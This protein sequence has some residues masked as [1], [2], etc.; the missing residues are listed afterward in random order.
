MIYG[1][2]SVTYYLA[3]IIIAVRATQTYRAK[4]KPEREVIAE[5]KR[6]KILKQIETKEETALRKA[7]EYATAEKDDEVAVIRPI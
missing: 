1:F 4:V 5:E 7:M 6:D 2:V 3:S